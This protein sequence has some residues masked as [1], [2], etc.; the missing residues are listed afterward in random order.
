MNKKFIVQ[1]VMLEKAYF[2]IIEDNEILKTALD[3]M[4]SFSH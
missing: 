4:N 1:E 3:K 2:P